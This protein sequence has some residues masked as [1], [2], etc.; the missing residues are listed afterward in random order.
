MADIRKLGDIDKFKETQIDILARSLQVLNRGIRSDTPVDTG[1]LKASWIGS[2]GKPSTHKPVYKRPYSGS[3]AVDVLPHIKPGQT[4][5]YVNN[6]D[7]APHIEYGTSKIR[8]YAMLR[9]NIARWPGIV[10]RAAV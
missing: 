7:Y 1:T 9:K 10:K 3:K 8:P 2:I 5:Y 6:Q 4:Y